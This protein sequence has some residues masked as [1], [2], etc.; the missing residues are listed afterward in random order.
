MLLN[1]KFRRVIARFIPAATILTVSFLAH[2]VSAHAANFVHHHS[3]SCIGS[4]A[5]ICTDHSFS[6]ENTGF[7]VAYCKSCLMY[8]TPDVVIYREVCNKG[9]ID[10]I[11]YKSQICPNCFHEIY[12][13]P[14]T[15]AA[16]HTYYEDD[17]ICGFSEGEVVGS[18]S[19]SKSTSEWTNQD[20]TISAN[21]SSRA[22][23]FNGSLVTYDFGNGASGTSSHTV[24][25]NGTYT[26]TVNY[27]GYTSVSE[28]IVVSNIDK[29]APQISLSKS[30]D[31]WT[32][33][34]VDVYVNASDDESG[35]AEAAYS[36]NSGA[37]GSGSSIH[38]GSN[39]TV[40]VKVIDKAGNVATGSIMISN[41]GKDPAV[42]EAERLEAERK[43]AE[44]LEKERLEKE[45]LEAIKKAEE[46]KKKQELLNSL[47][48][49]EET[50]QPNK[51]EDV[52]TK[53][54]SSSNNYVAGTGS[55]E[56]TKTPETESSTHK[57][58]L[59]NLIASFT[60][61][62]KNDSLEQ[63]ALAENE[64]KSSKNLVSVSKKT[65]TSQNASNIGNEAKDS[66]VS[67][68]IKLDVSSQKLKSDDELKKTE[69]AKATESYETMT[70]ENEYENI[71]ATKNTNSSV[72]A[73]IVAGV[74]VLLLGL[75]LV[76]H[77]NYIYYRKDGKIKVVSAAKA[78]VDDKRIIV[79]INDKKLAVGGKFF[80]CLSPWMKLSKKKKHVYV[81]IKNQDILIG[82]DESLCFSY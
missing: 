62:S 44:R 22:T 73:Y 11:E 5:K 30:T 60:G 1:Y 82:T 56:S 46:E 36:F 41:I 10:P 65:N 55:L 9:L 68:Y 2:P 32:E 39:G 25:A 31:K 69:E 78:K 21:V 4:V 67:H 49:K 6:Y 38:V 71:S 27:P 13:G 64:T 37:Y 24:S 52:T 48:K 12:H 8:S 66:T 81:Q 70:L 74:M 63:D 76:S 34:G 42:I 40:S 54:G 7:S 80:I 23:G 29:T 47:N 45:R 15:E 3:E 58:P 75:M 50:T 28:S 79:T 14:I 17:Y 26:V 43:E 61:T 16:A 51:K 35:L 33:S 53:P 18:V 20:V 77:F 19:L 72:Y 59:G 57:N